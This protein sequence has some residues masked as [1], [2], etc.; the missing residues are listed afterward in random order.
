MLETVTAEGTSTAVGIA[1]KA[2]ILAPARNPQTSTAAGP[3][4][5]QERT[6]TSGALKCLSFRSQT[7]NESP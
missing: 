2:D 3:T 5:A 1:A 6:E 7:K 4:A